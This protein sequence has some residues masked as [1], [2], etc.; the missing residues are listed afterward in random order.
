MDVSRGMIWS[1]Q[2]CSPFHI[3]INN[4]MDKVF[5]EADLSLH[6]V[7]FE[8]SQ[9]NRLQAH[10]LKSSPS[11]GWKPG[12]G[13]SEKEKAGI[14]STEAQ[15]RHCESLYVTPQYFNGILIPNNNRKNKW[16]GTYFCIMHLCDHPGTRNFVTCEILLLRVRA[17]QSFITTK[18]RC[19]FRSDGFRVSWH[20]TTTNT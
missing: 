2:P 7:L 14:H 6:L 3:N 13:C 10:Y 19:T 1:Q 9:A 4:N 18:T 17:R 11:T 16:V 8:Q 20:T 5:A 15:S 12:G